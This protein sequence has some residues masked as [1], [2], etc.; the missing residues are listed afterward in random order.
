MLD[1]GKA[2]SLLFSDRRWLEKWIIGAL[3]HIAAVL[4]IGIPFLLGYLLEVARRAMR[5]EAFDLPE[6]NERWGEYF[7]RG[8]VFFIIAIIYH[9]PV[10]FTSLISGCLT[11]PYLLLVYFIFP[12]VTFRVALTGDLASAFQFREI[13]EFVQNNLANLLVVWFVGLLGIVVASFGVL[14]FLIGICFSAFW[15]EVALFYLAGSLYRV[16]IK[17]PAAEPPASPASV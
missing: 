4:I 11:L 15:A 16:A 10:I 8:L 13:L 5:E 14:A 6:W 1:V 7:G 3:L 17:P 9:L 2:F 12:V